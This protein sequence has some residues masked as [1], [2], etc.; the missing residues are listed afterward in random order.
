MLKKLYAM[1]VV[2]GAFIIVPFAMA[3]ATLPAVTGLTARQADNAVVLGWE[4]AKKNVSFDG[5]AVF[6]SERPGLLGTIIGRTGKDKRLFTDTRVVTKQ[7]YYYRVGYY[8]GKVTTHG[9]KQVKVNI[10]TAVT[11]TTTS[12]PAAS[13][14]KS[15]TVSV[16]I[17]NFSFQPQTLT[18][19]SGTTVVWTNRDSA[20]H[21]ATAEERSFSSDTLNTNGKYSHTFTTVGTFSYFCTFHPSMQAKVIVQ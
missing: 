15:P 9:G 18:V 14:P 4:K 3:A 19:A 5:Y 2:V 12:T 10:K 13:A 8:R 21:T 1:A 17:S 16:D 7:T 6:R 20:A 11:S